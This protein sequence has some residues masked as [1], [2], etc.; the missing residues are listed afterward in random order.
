[1]HVISPNTIVEMNELFELVGYNRE[2]VG[3]LQIE[4]MQETIMCSVS[5]AVKLAAC[6]NISYQAPI[7]ITTVWMPQYQEYSN[8]KLAKQAT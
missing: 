6:W 5:T 8:G 7:E 3:K 2:F 4:V 1:M